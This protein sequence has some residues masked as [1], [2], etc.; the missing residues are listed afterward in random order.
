MSNISRD[1]FVEKIQRGFRMHNVVAL[2]G[3]RQCG[4]TTLAN[5]FATSV[6]QKGKPITKF[7]LEDPQHLRQLEQPKLALEQLKGLIVIDE[8]Q[9][10]P[11]LFPLL[12]VLVDQ[13]KSTQQY[14]LLGS[15][16]RDLIKQSSETLA[17]RIFYLELTPFNL[18]ETNDLQKNWLLGGFPLS[19]I[20]PGLQDS[21]DW[22]NNYVKTFLERDIPNLGFDVSPNL[23]RRFWNM[24]AHYHG[25]ILNTSELGRAIGVSHTTIKKYIDILVGTFMVRELKPW[26]ENISKR[27]VK[28][29]KIYLRD[30]GLLHYLLGVFDKNNLQQHPKIGAS[31]EGFALE[32]LIRKLELDAEDC[33]FWATHQGAELDLLTYKYGKK[34]GYE[35][36]YQ[37]APGMTKS[38]YSVLDSLNLEKIYIIY[39]GAKNYRIHENVEVVAIENLMQ[40]DLEK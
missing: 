8:V 34:R 16:S 21:F 31:W 12:R 24:L 22:R 4:K 25:N 38:L 5:F 28:Q 14:L 23:L 3:P 15:A 1:D 40:S 29:S 10:K 13:N 11:D 39:P 37:D 2:L 18:R 30:S 27:Q 20:A 26:Y 36:K 17:G 7:D 9:N 35:F 19:Y 33:Y 6:R 32:E